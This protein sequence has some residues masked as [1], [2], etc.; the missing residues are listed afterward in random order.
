MFLNKTTVNFV[1]IRRR[2]RRRRRRR[3]YVCFA[4]FVS[5]WRY[6]SIFNFWYNGKMENICIKKKL[7]QIIEKF[8]HNDSKMETHFMIRRFEI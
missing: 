3:L 8:Y 2:R 7:T 4:K 6:S 5:R 1:T